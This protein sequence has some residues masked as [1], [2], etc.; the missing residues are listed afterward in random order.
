[1]AN[2]L[3]FFLVF[4]VLP[5]VISGIIVCAVYGRKK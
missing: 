5:V 2:E 1:M 3:Q 4:I